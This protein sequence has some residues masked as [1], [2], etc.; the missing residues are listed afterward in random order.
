MSTSIELGESS[1][2]EKL[3][4]HV[5]FSGIEGVLSVLI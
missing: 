1:I 5:E 4:C 3:G 2:L